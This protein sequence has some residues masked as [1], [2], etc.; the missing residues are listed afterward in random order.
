MKRNSL[1][2]VAAIT[3]LVLTL[4]ACDFFF[5]TGHVQFQNASGDDI[6]IDG[7][8]FADAE[9]DEF[10]GPFPDGT[11]VPEG[12]AIRA[13]AT[14]SSRVEGLFGDTWESLS[15]SPSYEIDSNERYVI[16]IGPQDEDGEYEF[17]FDKQ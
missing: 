11:T 1:F 2:Y 15:G 16:I 3:A 13:S 9:Y 7:I 14:R 12:E 5:G 4:G 17:Q 8:R 10:E 6:A